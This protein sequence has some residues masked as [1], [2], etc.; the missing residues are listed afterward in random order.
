M[1]TASSK[2]SPHFSLIPWQC[3]SLFREVCH[4]ALSAPPLLDL[5]GW[6]CAAHLAAR[7]LSGSGRVPSAMTLW[8]FR[9]T[10]LLCA[11]LVTQLI[12][13]AVE[14]EASSAL[15]PA[16]ETAS[17]LQ[18]MANASETYNGLCVF[19]AAPGLSVSL[20][21]LLEKYFSCVERY[22]AAGNRSALY[23]CLGGVLVRLYEAHAAMCRRRHDTLVIAAPT[24]PGLGTGPGLAVSVPRGDEEQVGKAPVNSHDPAPDL[25]SLSPGTSTASIESVVAWCRR[26]PFWPGSPRS[27][28]HQR[29]T[30]SQTDDQEQE[31]EPEKT[32]S[33]LTVELADP[34]AAPG[35]R[36]RCKRQRS[37]GEE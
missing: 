35:R 16:S 9:G 37:G 25:I 4:A 7:K 31:Q 13:S 3:I 28:G 36:V 33:V 5:L 24:A 10:A 11:D 30:P 15:A 32:M 14:A 21:E 20:Y 27:S 29:A 6:S 34:A 23:G 8:L 17:A 12:D 19:P 1:A 26:Q 18:Y 2:H 22:L